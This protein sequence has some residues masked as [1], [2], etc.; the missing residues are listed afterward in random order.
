V[1]AESIAAAVR[2]AQPRLGAT[3]LVLVDGPAGSGK[4]TLANDV[5]VALGGAP[6][7]GAGTFDPAAP[8]PAIPILHGDDMYEGW[9][10]LTSLN[11]VLVGQVLEPLSHGV[12]GGF[13]MWDWHRSRRTHRIPVPPTQFLVV[14]GVGVASRAA[15]DHASFVAYVEAPWEARLARGVARDGE[16]MRDEWLRWHPIEDQYLA[17][18][19]TR[20]AA[21]V[22]VDGTRG[23]PD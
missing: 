22:V 10:G 23:R 14:E 18:Q 11:D 2:A 5:A 6:S 13:R 17:E 12:E 20:E 21:D 8:L 15:R 9:S 1:R 4:T 3:R 7:R 19:G 16:A